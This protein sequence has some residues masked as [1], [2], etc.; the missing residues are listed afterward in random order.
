M[1]HYKTLDE[2]RYDYVNN[3]HQKGIA[4]SLTDYMLFDFSILK[5]II[6]LHK[7]ANWEKRTV[8][9]II[10][11]ADTETSKNHPT[12][13]EILKD[14]TRKPIAQPCHLVCWTITLRAYGTNIV[15]LRGRKPTELA[16]CIARIHDALPGDITYIF[17]HY[18]SYDWTFLERFIFKKLGFP[19]KQLNTKSHYP[20][21]IEFQGGIILRDSLI[22]L[23][24]GLEKA[25]ED[26][27]VMHKKQTGSWDYKKIRHQ[28][29]PLD[30]QEWEYAEFD[31]L[32][33]A[34]CIDAYCKGLQKNLASL[35]LTATGI[36]RGDC[37]NI[38]KAYRWHDTFEKQA[39]TYE[40]YCTVSEH[41]FHGGYT[42]GNRH[43]V[44]FL[45]KELVRCFD[46]VSSYPFIMLAFKMPGSA[47]TPIE[48][49]TVKRVLDNM[50]DYA[51]YFKLIMMKPELKD[52]S[53]PMP[54]LQYSKC[55]GTVN[56][57]IDNG[58]I[59]SAEYAEI[60]C[61]EYDLAIICSQYRFKGEPIILNGQISVKQYLPR[62]LTDYIYELFKAKCIDK[63]ADPFDAIIYALDKS[64]I[65]AIFGMT[66]QRV[67]RD[68]LEEDYNTGEFKPKPPKDPKAKYD[69]EI[70]KS[71]SFLNYQIGVWV[72]S[73]G[74]YNLMHLVKCAGTAYYCDTDSCYGSDWD[75]EKVAAYNESCKKKLLANGYGPVMVKGKE[76]W[77]GIA[78]SEGD[79]DCYTEFKYMGAKRYAG[80]KKSDGKVHITVAG[81][82]KSSGMECM[83]DDMENFHPGFVFEGE[84]TGKKTHTYLYDDI[85]TDEFG[86]ECANSVDLTECDYKLD[87][88]EFAELEDILA[89]EVDIIEFSEELLF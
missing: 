65:N 42:H 68:E 70:K 32:S 13:Y 8:N 66:V 56:A 28:N 61:T 26:L 84:K 14:G 10:I 41:L 57:I 62:W 11:M 33:G 35:P 54:F 67:L 64:K 31:T 20:V 30:P 86:N 76:M 51:F 73:I 18:L 82:P 29:T 89:D 75:L 25:A 45:I 52:D 22:L 78:E 27:D 88:T 37:R 24:R 48:D 87:K 50:D 16:D 53:I 15:T 34:E 74:V 47:F 7:Q 46:F 5:G 4:Y 2:K 21:Q 44:D 79:K 36:P 69:E 77:L 71:T 12:Q 1:R 80:R 85:H 81:V 3:L 72:T 43:F 17:F 59:L 55:T 9:D 38:S 39:L 58:R 19:V 23:Q 6:Q 60:W 63:V 40:Q 83:N 49:L